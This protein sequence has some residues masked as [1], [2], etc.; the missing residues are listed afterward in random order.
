VIDNGSYIKMNVLEI[1]PATF[2]V[3]VTLAT[4]HELRLGAGNSKPV[5]NLSTDTPLEHARYQ[6]LAAHHLA[7]DTPIRTCW[8]NKFMAAASDLLVVSS[9]VLHQAPKV[10]TGDPLATIGDNCFDDSA[11]MMDLSPYLDNWI[12][13]SPQSSLT[14][15]STSSSPLCAF[16]TG[17]I[18]DSSVSGVL[19][20]PILLDGPLN[21]AASDDLDTLY[22]HQGICGLVN[23]GNTCF[24]NSALQCLSNTPQLSR[25]F[26][27]KGGRTSAI[28]PL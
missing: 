12:D 22:Q 24:M 15:P 14:L 5:I 3:Y 1:Y 13:P 23:L 10:D 11:L 25:W 8:V 2:D 17:F 20:S 21:S 6:L 18:K 28:E 16:G 4:G 7:Q 26:L 27:G 19:L 9:L